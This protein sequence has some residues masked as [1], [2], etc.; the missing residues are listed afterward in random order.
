MRTIYLTENPQQ[1]PASLATERT[2]HVQVLGGERQVPECKYQ[3]RKYQNTKK[4][5]E[6]HEYD[7]SWYT[8]ERAAVKLKG[9]F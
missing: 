4:N 9:N 2:R 8:S 1:E 6:T 7:I 5:Y 3:V